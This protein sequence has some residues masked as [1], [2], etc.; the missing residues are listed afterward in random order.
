MIILVKLI[1]A[2]VFEF[3]FIPLLILV[4]LSVRLKNKKIDIGLGP[5]P[6]INNIYHKRA[7]HLAGYTAETFVTAIWHITSDFDKNF[8]LKHTYLSVKIL[9]GILNTLQSVYVFIWCIAR[10]KCVI[11]Y[12]NGGPLGLSTRFLWRLEPLLFRWSNV[13]TII[14]PYGADVQDMSRSK[15][16][17]FKHGMSCDYPLHKNNRQRIAGMIDLWTQK[18]DHVVGGCEW[19]DY[20]YHWDTLTLAHFSIDTDLFSV[21]PK[22]TTIGSFSADRP[23]RVLHAPN[24]RAIKGTSFFIN[25][26]ESL[27]S[28]GYPIELILV[29]KLP[30][31]EIKRLIQSV[32][33]VL[34]QLVVGWYAMFA[35]EAMASGKPVICYLRS[36]LEDLYIAAGLISTIEEIPIIRATPFDIKQVL[37]DIMDNPKILHSAAIGGPEFVKKHHSVQAISEIFAPILKILLNS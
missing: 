8:S 3:A 9:G 17:I 19:V 15:N 29:E 25:A 24:H 20:M 32:D 13:K 27:K 31:S 7:V 4:S 36:D 1:L 34:D 23:M 10:Y 18:G 21:D 35:I 30:N 12:F 33:L 11:L 6:L 2:L 16:L 22:I 37:A 14:L 5:L 28:E 26:I